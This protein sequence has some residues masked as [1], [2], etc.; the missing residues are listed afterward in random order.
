MFWSVNMARYSNMWWVGMV[1]VLLL[2]P[3]TAVAE[4]I[5]IEVAP[6]TL[7][8]ASEGQVVTV[9][10]D[11]AYADVVVSSVYLNEVYIDSWKADNRGNFVAK[12]LMGAVKTIPGLRIGEA[13]TLT[14]VGVTVDGISFWGEQ[15]V[16]VIDVTGRATDPGDSL[17]HT[18]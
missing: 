12:F 1:L 3:V 2:A 14:M 17:I 18:Y 4:E 13:N 15:E 8:L 5:I 11:V 6:R 9:H 7:N 16:M 10:T